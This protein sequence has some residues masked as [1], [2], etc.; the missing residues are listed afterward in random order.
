MITSQSW[1][2]EG[3]HILSLSL[4]VSNTHTHART[5]YRKSFLHT[6]LTYNLSYAAEATLKAVIFM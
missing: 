6:D 2:L 3:E 4:S 5:E 1:R